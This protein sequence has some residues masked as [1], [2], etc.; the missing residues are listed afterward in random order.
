MVGD[1]EIDPVHSRDITVYI[2]SGLGTRQNP[3]GGAERRCWG[4][5]T[6]GLPRLGCCHHDPYKRQKM[7]EWTDR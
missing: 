1:T 4:E 5:E 6:S 7:D 2:S 3:P